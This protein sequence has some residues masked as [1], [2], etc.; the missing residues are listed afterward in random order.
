MPARSFMSDH[1]AYLRL[2]MAFT[3]P[4]ADR[5]DVI[6][7]HSLH[8]LPVAMAPLLPIPMLTTLHTPPTPWL[9]SAIQATPASSRAPAPFAAVERLH[10]RASGAC[11]GP[12]PPVGGAERRRRLDV[13]SRSGGRRAHL[14]GAHRAREGA[15]PGDPGG[16][17]GRD[18]AGR[19]R[20][21]ERPPV[22][23]AGRPA[24][25]G[26]RRG[27]RRSPPRARALRPRGVVRG[28]PRHARS[29]TSPTAWWSPRLSPA[30]RPSWP[31]NGAVSLRSLRI[32]RSAALSRP[33]DV[34]AMA[35]A[36]SAVVDL[37]RVAVREYAERYLSVDRMVTRVRAGVPA[38][39]VRVHRG[40][41]PD[42]VISPSAANASSQPPMGNSPHRSWNRLLL[43]TMSAR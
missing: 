20:T 14:V 39:G 3:G 37:D 2:L 13:A 29:G 36:V 22:L 41:R 12:T 33:G 30:A 4:L 24:A 23:R 26:S 16:P 43:R 27:V 19:G 18:A 38:A 5:F 17:A 11:S 9:E 31:S 6:H 10:R 42:S 28:R 35:D 32:R 15:A 21:D 25:P 1:H 7:N 40:G 34:Q 8:H